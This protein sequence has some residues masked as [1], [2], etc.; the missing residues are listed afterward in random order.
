MFK[1][2]PIMALVATA[3]TGSPMALLAASLPARDA[4]AGTAAASRPRL[5]RAVHGKHQR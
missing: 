2:L 3:P 1:M 5:T 4:A